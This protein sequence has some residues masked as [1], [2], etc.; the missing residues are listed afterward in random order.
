MSKYKLPSLHEPS[1]N[2]PH[3]G[4]LAN[5]QWSKVYLELSEDDDS[6]EVKG[7]IANLCFSCKKIGLWLEWTRKLVYPAI[8]EGNLPDPNQDLDEDIQSDYIEAR[9][10]LHLSPRGA[11]AILRLCLQKL[12][13]QL[14]EKGKNI[15][16]DIAALVKKG[17]NPKIQKALDV[18][19]V[20]GNNAVHPGEINIKDDPQ[21]ALNLLNLINL[22]ADAMIS[23]PKHIDDLF[24]SLP[25]AAL[26]AIQKRDS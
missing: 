9:N 19:R 16:D 11:T 15:N 21:T 17:L 10:I 3:C 13:I 14:G 24:E 2:C 18:V 5:Q 1:F 25:T 22:I 20:I 7:Y 26:Q 12:C 23:Q 8:V 4:A 6:V